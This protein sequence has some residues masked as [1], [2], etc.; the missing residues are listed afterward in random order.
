MSRALVRAAVVAS[1]LAACT[2]DVELAIVLDF[3]VN[4]NEAEGFATLD[5]IGRRPA[6]TDPITG[7]A[8]TAFVASRIPPRAVDSFVL[9][10]AAEESW[11]WDSARVSYQAAARS[12]G[13]FEAEAAL[14]RD[15]DEST[16]S[17]SVPDPGS[18]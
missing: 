6:W 4:Y 3:P 9:G 10:L 15:P 17:P 8:P 18:R 5:E 2:N 12:E 7:A 11:R 14:E 1:A 16:E 13:F